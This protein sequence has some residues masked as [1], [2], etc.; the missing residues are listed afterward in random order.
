MNEGLNRYL[1]II[2]GPTASGKTDV[3]VQLAEHFNTEI[4]SADSRQMYRELNIGTAK[5]DTS[6]LNKVRHHFINNLSVHDYYNASMFE[7]QALTV[8]NSLFD[9]NKYVILAGGSGL[10][11]DAVCTGI[12][13]YPEADQQLRVELEA[14]YQKEGLPYLRKLLKRYDP[15]YYNRV[16]LRNP[17][18]MMKGIEISM[19]TGKPYSDYLTAQKKNRNFEI[20]RIALNL[21]RDVLYERINSRCD[22]ML[23]HGLHKEIEE[24]APLKHLNALNTVGYKEF[25][26]YKKGK[27][28][29]EEAIRLFKRNTRHYARRQITW[30]NR[31]NNYSWFHPEDTDSII[32]HIHKNS[33]L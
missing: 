11:I 27:Y 19:T 33:T 9:K 24:L 2:A 31:H 22:E 8:L 20:I 6:T 10:Y 16:D 14:K 5:P 28:P 26:E 3:A 12:D 23:S 1:I 25:F 32:Q 30:F 4:I 7:A 21:Q 17:K 13:S 29:M 15:E 18:R